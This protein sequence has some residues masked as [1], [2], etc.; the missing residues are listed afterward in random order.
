MKSRLHGVSN[1]FDFHHPIVQESFEEDAPAIQHKIQVHAEG[2]HV[3]WH[4]IVM[5]VS[6]RP[7][8]VKLAADRR[9]HLF[10]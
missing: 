6:Y 10:I 2:A 1:Q 8:Y 5:H 9:L 4:Q 3:L 7:T